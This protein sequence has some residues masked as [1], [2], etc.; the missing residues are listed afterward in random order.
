MRSNEA[1]GFVI[2]GGLFDTF[3]FRTGVQFMKQLITLFVMF[4]MLPPVCVFGHHGTGI[5]YDLTVQPITVKATVKEFR[6]ANPHVSIFIDAPNEN[7]NVVEWSIEGN[8]PFNWMRMGWNRNTLKP[9]DQVTITFYRSKV[10][11]VYAGVIAKVILPDGKE[12]L[13][14]QRDNPGEEVR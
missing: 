11:D 4:T 8:S 9:G 12:A 5:S 1:T 3:I 2:A 6:W 13:R 14:F 7:G 10:K